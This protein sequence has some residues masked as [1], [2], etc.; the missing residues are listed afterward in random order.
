M[1]SLHFDG[2]AHGVDDAP[3]LDE[4]AIDRPLDGTS[5]MKSDGRVEQITAESA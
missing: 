3:E 5:T 1:R 4:H 2:A